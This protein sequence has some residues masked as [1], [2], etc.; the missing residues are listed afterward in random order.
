MTSEYEIKHSINP[1]NYKI[2]SEC[3]LYAKWFSDN[4]LTQDKSV[5]IQTKYNLIEVRSLIFSYEANDFWGIF[6]N[7]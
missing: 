4:I 3:I 5:E 6:A 2:I 1:F 7:F